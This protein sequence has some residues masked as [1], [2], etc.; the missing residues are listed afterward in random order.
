MTKE[1]YFN[2]WGKLD[3]YDT[4]ALDIHNGVILKETIGGKPPLIEIC[5]TR[6]YIKNPLSQIS[7]Y[8]ESPKNKIL[9]KLRRIKTYE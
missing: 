3:F 2:L 8:D 9:S 6:F 7:N 5:H 4:M 1:Q